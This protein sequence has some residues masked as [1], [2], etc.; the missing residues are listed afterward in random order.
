VEVKNVHMKEGDKAT[1]PDAVTARGLKHLKEMTQMVRDG[2]RAVMIYCVQRMDCV[3]FDSDDA[4][5]PDYGAGL[6]QAIK[7]GVEAYAYACN[8][9]LAGINLTTALPIE[10]TT[11]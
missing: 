7:D 1:F 8:I 5:D 4:V 2:H 11:P 3:R 9:T 10:L 6:R